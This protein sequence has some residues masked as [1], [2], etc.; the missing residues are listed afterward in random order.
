M[1]REKRALLVLVPGL[2][3]QWC[4]QI[5]GI[6]CTSSFGGQV[7]VHNLHACTSRKMTETVNPDFSVTQHMIGEQQLGLAPARE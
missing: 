6:F 1:L 2:P 4:P 5:P 7:G 3:A